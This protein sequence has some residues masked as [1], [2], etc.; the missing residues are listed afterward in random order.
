MSMLLAQ[1]LLLWTIS[2]MAKQQHRLTL[3]K[4]SAG[5]RN[6][7]GMEA[8]E[9]KH[10]RRK[11]KAAAATAILTILTILTVPIMVARMMAVYP[12]KQSLHST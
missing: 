10:Q 12:R 3:P 11:S 7:T 1:P 9:A 8:R 4:E 5:E 6:K 2:A